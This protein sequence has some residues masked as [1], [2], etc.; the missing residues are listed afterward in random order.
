MPP[1]D[2]NGNWSGKTIRYRMWSRLGIPSLSNNRAWNTL[3]NWAQE[4]ASAIGADIFATPEKFIRA[5]G[6][7]RERFARIIEH[8]HVCQNG[9]TLVEI[10]KA[11]KNIEAQSPELLNTKSISVLTGSSM[12]LK[13]ELIKDPVGVRNEPADISTDLCWT[14]QTF[15]K[16]TQCRVVRKA[17]W[18]QA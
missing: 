8:L 6:D 4:V 9:R 11:S 13:G 18:Q 7:R 12:A 10:H 16:Q 1:Q 5:V 14:F 3:A 15:S 2:W 17:L